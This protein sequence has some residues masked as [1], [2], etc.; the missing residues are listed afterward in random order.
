M[1]NQQ[2]LII[3]NKINKHDKLNMNVSKSHISE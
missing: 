3:Y 1:L 2:L